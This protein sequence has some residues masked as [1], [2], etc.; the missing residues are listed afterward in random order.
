[1]NLK[2]QSERNASHRFCV[3]KHEFICQ[4]KMV[5]T[6]S[7]NINKMNMLALDSQIHYLFNIL[8]RDPSKSKQICGKISE[9]EIQH[10]CDVPRW[11]LSLSCA[12]PCAMPHRVSCLVMCHVLLC[13]LSRLAPTSTHLASPCHVLPLPLPICR[14]VAHHHC[15]CRTANL[16]QGK[17]SPFPLPLASSLVGRPT[18]RMARITLQT[19]LAVRPS[20]MLYDQTL[21]PQ[22]PYGPQTGCTENFE[23][24]QAVPHGH[25][26]SNPIQNTQK[27]FLPLS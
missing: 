27:T 9:T 5:N 3:S 6:R 23:L 4:Q 8:R 20:C 21:V 2:N 12:S 17:A 26:T 14:T 24:P 11:V 18:Y 10:S 25:F 16:P 15:R 13:V 22:W 1:M 19:P 7:N